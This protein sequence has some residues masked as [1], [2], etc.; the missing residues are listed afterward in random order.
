[1]RRARAWR[2]AP[3]SP[4]ALLSV[5][6]ALLTVV[7]V[8]AGAALGNSTIGIP[9]IAVGVAC[10]GV[11]AWLRGRNERRGHR[12]S[13]ALGYWLL[14]LGLVVSFREVTPLYRGERTDPPA[15]ATPSV[16]AG[17]CIDVDLVAISCTAPHLA[18]VIFVTDYPLDA[19]FPQP[20]DRFFHRWKQ[21]NCAQR[22]AAY[23][24]VSVGE[25]TYE[26]QVLLQARSWSASRRPVLCAVANADSS[27]LTQSVKGTYE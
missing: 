27:P 25:S 16:L 21:R 12:I 8:A 23:V 18:E 9:V 4:D 14:I 19:P 10:F 20:Q 3:L 7:G 2:P 13:R 22:F 5:L 11:G 17:D 6:G 26:L 1:M 24:G 15:V